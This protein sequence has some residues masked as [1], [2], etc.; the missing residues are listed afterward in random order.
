[1]LH[2]P[3]KFPYPAYGQQPLG[4]A[5]LIAG[6][7]KISHDVFLKNVNENRKQK[8]LLVPEKF[9]H[10]SLPNKMPV[11]QPEVVS[12]V[13]LLLENI[14]FFPLSC[15]L[16]WLLAFGNVVGLHTPETLVFKRTSGAMYS[17]MKFPKSIGNVGTPL[18][19]SLWIVSAL[20]RKE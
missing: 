6:S 17:P 1:M 15:R 3:G 10:H 20:S 14:R 9:E 8:L 12:G 5:M 4:F 19:S 13:L 7:V 16:L 18:L 2:S 11:S